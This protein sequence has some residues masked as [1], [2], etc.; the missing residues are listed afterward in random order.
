MATSAIKGYRYPRRDLTQGSLARDLDWAAR[1]RELEQAGEIPL[2]IRQTPPRVHRQAAVLRRPQA[3][4]IPAVLGVMA[5]LAVAVLLLL[6]YVELMTLSADTVALNEQLTALQAQHVT[7]TAAHEQMFD[8]AAVKEAAA[9]AGMSKPAGSQVCYLDM[10]GEDSAV[11]YATAAPSV[12][13]RIFSSLHHGVYAV[14][15]YF[16]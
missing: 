2:P 3:V 6:S 11:V 14:V 10:L 8:M 5:I 13:E 1:K 15:E 9:A 12:L 4:S 16:H 7:L